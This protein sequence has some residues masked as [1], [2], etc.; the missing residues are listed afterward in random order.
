[1]SLL[2]STPSL[3]QICTAT[4]GHANAGDGLTAAFTAANSV[5]YNFDSFYV[6]SGNRQSNFGMY[7][8]PTVTVSTMG[9]NWAYNSTSVQT[10]TVQC[11]HSKWKF[12]SGNSTSGWTVSV[13]D[14]NNT[15]KIGDYSTSTLW[16]SNLTVR[17]NPNS[18]NGGSSDVTGILYCGTYNDYLVSNAYC[19]LDQAYNAVAPTFSFQSNGLTL[20]NTSY[21][22]QVGSPAITISW[23]PS[24][25]ATSPHIN[26]I[27]IT[28]PGP[29]NIYSGSRNN[30]YNGVAINTWSI[31]L[32]ENVQYNTNYLVEIDYTNQ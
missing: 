30:C 25:M 6:G 24:G 10:F 21:T 15:N 17:V 18:T 16:D 13:W 4:L 31:T 29:T 5:P 14:I 9:L 1:M 3:S 28:K 23:T 12:Y 22:Y 20:S 2:S 26:Y 7:G 19:Y 32:S 8:T 11:N 27:Y